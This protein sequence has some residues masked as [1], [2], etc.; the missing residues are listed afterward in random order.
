MINMGN[1]YYDKKYVDR[2]YTIISNKN[3]F[4]NWYIPQKN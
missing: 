1:I 4:A 2:K 3:N